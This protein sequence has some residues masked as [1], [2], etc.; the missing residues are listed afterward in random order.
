[1]I[2]DGWKPIETAPKD[3][4]HVLLLLGESIPDVPYVIVGSFIDG[5]MAE[6][7]GYREY[8]KYGAWLIWNSGV[9]FYCVDVTDPT[10]FMPLPTSPAADGRVTATMK[11]DR[12][13]DW[14]LVP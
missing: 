6:E 8:A 13:N 4:S 10:H 9:D 5:P 14:A 3:G 2:E 7:L 12:K 11:P 1:M